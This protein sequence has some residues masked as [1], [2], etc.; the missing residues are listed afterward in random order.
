M[1][2]PITKHTSGTRGIA[3]LYALLL[4][5]ILVTAFLI[6]FS[7]TY[8]QIVTARTY[9]DG[10]VAYRA[11]LNGNAC[12]KMWDDYFNLDTNGSKHLYDHVGETIS[13]QGY[14]DIT[15]DQVSSFSDWW[16][17]VL[18][19]PLTSPEGPCSIVF[20]HKE[21]D[22]GVTFRVG[23]YSLG[24]DACVSTNPRRVQRIIKF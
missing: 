4:T 22:G 8:R 18:S 9:R 19:P 13:C 10:I 14:H 3:L 11:T 16:Q 1:L 5:T 24:K 2:N 12:A 23:G 17:I 6:L 7:I 21:L 20:V 15:I